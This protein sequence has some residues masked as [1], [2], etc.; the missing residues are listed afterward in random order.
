MD[1]Y[2]FCENNKFVSKFDKDILNQN[3]K[4]DVSNYKLE[5]SMIEKIIVDIY[6]KKFEKELKIMEVKKTKNN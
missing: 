3:L 2:L 1:D 6:T 4:K 5:K